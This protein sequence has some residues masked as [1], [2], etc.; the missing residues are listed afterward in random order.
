MT[1]AQMDAK[2]FANSWRLLPVRQNMLLKHVICEVPIENQVAFS[3]G[4][5]VWNSLRERPGFV[6]QLGG[7]LETKA[8]IF[9]LWT[10]EVTYREFMAAH[11]DQIAA[12]GQQEQTYTAINVKLYILH[13]P[14]P[15][16]TDFAKALLSASA[17]EFAPSEAIIVVPKVMSFHC[18]SLKTQERE[19]I[20]SLLDTAKPPIHLQSEGTGP[21][22]MIQHFQIQLLP[23][24]N[25]TNAL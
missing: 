5:R 7:F 17:C 11:H 13:E 18:H 4:Q 3:S 24:W 10:N 15:T 2:R 8:H 16:P 20:F 6:A 12:L 14:A 9:G 21:L 22:S 19:V 23:E 1:R 25:V